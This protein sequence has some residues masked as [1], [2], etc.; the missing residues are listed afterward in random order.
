MPEHKLTIAQLA[1]DV[2]F[3]DFKGTI[4]D[5]RELDIG[6]LIA[7]TA[8]GAVHHGYWQREEV[9]VKEL[10]LHAV[11]STDEKLRTFYAFRHEVWMMSALSHP[12]IVQ[13]R[14]FSLNPFFLI[15]EWVSNGDL[16]QWLHKPDLAARLT[17][18]LRQRMAL[19]IANAMAFLHSQSPPILHRDL[20]SPNV[21]VASVDLN[22]PVLAKVADFG[23]AS[24][25]FISELKEKT[26]S[27]AV[28]TPT[29][30]VSICLVGSVTATMLTPI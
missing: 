20:K 5:P 3:A 1:P 29:W 14:A 15:L 11:T 4:V 25:L 16:Y 30:Y 18:P 28:E 12:N 19:D 9:A 21:F 26:K 22:S 27:R 8:F 7:N 10:R 13:L 17:V 24:R 6:D 2:A 23:L